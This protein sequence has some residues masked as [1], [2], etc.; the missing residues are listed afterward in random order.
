MPSSVVQEA[1][2]NWLG[3]HKGEEEMLAVVLSSKK[4][5]H[6]AGARW[7]RGQ[8]LVYRTCDG[9]FWEYPKKLVTRASH[10]PLSPGLT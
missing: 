5:V 8:L 4:R 6:A 9:Q 7:C 1:L 2:G 3:G 10:C